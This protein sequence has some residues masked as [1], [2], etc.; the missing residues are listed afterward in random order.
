MFNILYMVE[1]FNCLCELK[2]CP[3]EADTFLITFVLI[4]SSSSGEQ[5]NCLNVV[6]VHYGKFITPQRNP[7]GAQTMNAICRHNHVINHNIPHRETQN[8]AYF[9]KLS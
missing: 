4:L 9:S 3:G 6:E 7:R 2:Y 1:V 5:S 8:Y